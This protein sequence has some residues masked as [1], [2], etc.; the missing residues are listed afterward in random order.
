[1]TKAD[2]KRAAR[3]RNTPASK[4]TEAKKNRG[5]TAL[6][7]RLFPGSRYTKLVGGGG[8]PWTNG[9]TWAKKNIPV[10]DLCNGKREKKGGKG[11][12]KNCSKRSGKKGKNS[13]NGNWRRK[14]TEKSD[15]AYDKGKK[16]ENPLRGGGGGW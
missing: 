8:K 16:K 9:K 6:R 7:K 14:N 10:A 15:Y 12:G 1:L 13:V 2:R 4:F 3:P 5:E 11:K